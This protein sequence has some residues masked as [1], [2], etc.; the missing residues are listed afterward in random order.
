MYSRKIVLVLATIIYL[1]G[2]CVVSTS[3]QA[4]AGGAD[5]G[6]SKTA[7]AKKAP[8]LTYNYFKLSNIFGIKL[9]GNPQ[10]PATSPQGDFILV[11]AKDLDSLY[12]ISITK[13]NPVL[14]DFTINT[15]K[16][17][18]AVVFSKNGK[19]AYVANEGDNTVSIIRLKDTDSE[20]VANIPLNA[21]PTALAISKDNK[22]LYI[23]TKQDNRLNVVK[24]DDL[25]SKVINSTQVGKW[26]NSIK[27]S[28]DNEK[29]YI[30]NR[31]ENTISEVD[32]S[33]PTGNL[34]VKEIPVGTYPIDI[35]LSK[36]GDAAIITNL[37]DNSVSM[38]D[39]LENPPSEFNVVPNLSRPMA[40]VSDRNNEYAVVLNSDGG[41]L[42][43]YDLKYSSQKNISPMKHDNVVLEDDAEFMD[44][45]TRSNILTVTHP[46]KELISIVKYSIV[47]KPVEIINTTV[48]TP[49]GSAINTLPPASSM[50]NVPVTT[51]NV[52]PSSQLPS[53]NPA[54]DLRSGFQTGAPPASSLDFI[55]SLFKN[56]NGANGSYG[57]P[58]Q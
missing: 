1:A 23:T 52:A 18:V 27:L 58:N 55:N 57:F 12:Y 45:N 5:T 7:N 56:V 38:V 9:E 34:Q 49:G 10:K 47:K 17:P 11:P 15:G 37:I 26:P 29:A 3:S 19:V 54:Q 2:T 21:P 43:F 41:R 32:I 48:V 33:Y 40:T 46:K 42:D 14:K 30:V 22:Y 35:S 44:I 4:D 20:I 39:P 51:G 25:D 36:A 8:V 16:S 31:G 28:S 6:A 50:E 13:K 53:S 24:L